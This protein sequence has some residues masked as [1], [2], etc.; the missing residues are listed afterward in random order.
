MFLLISLISRFI[1]LIET[2]S[3]LMFHIAI[4]KKQTDQSI[5][6]LNK[7]ILLFLK[8][9]DHFYFLLV[10]FLVFLPFPLDDLNVFHCLI[11]LLPQPHLYQPFQ[12]DSEHILINIIIIGLEDIYVLLIIVLLLLIGF[13]LLPLLLIHLLIT[14]IIT[15]IVS[16]TTLLLF[17]LLPSY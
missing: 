7:F 10:Y 11:W 2:E 4:L 13:L 15:I 5:L 14:I 3:L 1:I 6:L 9:F 8:L 17:W 16:I 12:L